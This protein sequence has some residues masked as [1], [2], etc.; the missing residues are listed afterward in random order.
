[1]VAEEEGVAIPYGMDVMA[2]AMVAMQD[3][4][5]GVAEPLIGSVRLIPSFDK[6]SQDQSQFALDTLL[7]LGMPFPCTCIQSI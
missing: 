6:G 7:L 4:V 1:M 2:E 5:E 3:V